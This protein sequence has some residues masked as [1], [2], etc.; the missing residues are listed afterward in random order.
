M[1]VSAHNG[2]TVSV[3]VRATSPGLGPLPPHG[4]REQ[5]VRRQLHRQVLQHTMKDVVTVSNRCYAA[6][7]PPIRCC[8]RDVE[9][10]RGA[11][12]L[13]T[14]AKGKLAL[15]HMQ[16]TCQVQSWFTQHAETHCLAATVLPACNRHISAV[17]KPVGQ[18]ER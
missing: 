16:E 7:H 9:D 4:A 17:Y 15:H 1:H 3:L 13:L 10:A 8:I 6:A 12:C 2:D 14:S 11:A 5:V 18:A